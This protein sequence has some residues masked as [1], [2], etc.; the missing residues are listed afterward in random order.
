LILASGLVFHAGIQ[1]E[2]SP[3]YLDVVAV[4]ELFEGLFKLPL[5]DIAKRAHN[6]R[7][8]F[9]F[10]SGGLPDFWFFDSIK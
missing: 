1:L 7:P 3:F 6:I 2:A 8:Y 4:T 10:H 9:Y 5:A